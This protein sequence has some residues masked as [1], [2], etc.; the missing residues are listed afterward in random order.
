MDSLRRLGDRLDVI[1]TALSIAL[2]EP[3]PDHRSH[4]LGVLDRAATEVRGE[5]QEAEAAQQKR[6]FLR[7]VSPVPPGRLPQESSADV[8]AA[9][10]WRGQIPDHVSRSAG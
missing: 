6:S 9:E 7:L 10:R 3:A 8:A 5:H 4:L 2:Q 1:E